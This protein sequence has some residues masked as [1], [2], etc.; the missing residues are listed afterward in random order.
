[1]C[2]TCDCEADGVPQHRGATQLALEPPSVSRFK[3][4]DPQ[5]PR[6]FS[7]SGQMFFLDVEIIKIAESQVG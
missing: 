2:P 7:L 3:S 1:M 5:N 6:V 4:T